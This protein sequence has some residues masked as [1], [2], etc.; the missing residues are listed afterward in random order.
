MDPVHVALV[1]LPALLDDIVRALLD[2]DAGV[3]VVAAPTNADVVVCTAAEVLAS[4]LTGPRP[5]RVVVIAPDGRSAYLCAPSG[6]LSP[7]T[8]RAAIRGR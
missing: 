6:V 7:V 2:D 3:R 5:P 1:G 4:L 8:L